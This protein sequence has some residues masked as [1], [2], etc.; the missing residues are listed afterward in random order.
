MYELLKL[1]CLSC[2]YHWFPRKGGGGGGGGEGGLTITAFWRKFLPKGG[3]FFILQLYKKVGISLAHM[4][5]KGNMP[6]P[7][8]KGPE[9]ANRLILWM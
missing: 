3:T 6:F 9:K 4:K 7:S 8:V 5:G 2:N 1:A